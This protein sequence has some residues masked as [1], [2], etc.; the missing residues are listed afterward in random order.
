MEFPSVGMRVLSAG[1]RAVII[2]QTS[3]VTGNKSTRG[4]IQNIIMVFVDME[5]FGNKIIRLQLKVF[6]QSF[7]VPYLENRASGFTAVGTSQAIH[8]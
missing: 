7:D 1:I 8:P 2:N 5:V 4:G 6:G 3:V